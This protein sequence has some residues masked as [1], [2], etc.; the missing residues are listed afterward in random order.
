MPGVAFTL[1][2]RA[3]SKHGLSHIRNLTGI[4]VY[5]ESRLDV[6]RQGDNGRRLIRRSIRLCGGLR[7]RSHW[8]AMYGCAAADDLARTRFLVDVERQM[9]RS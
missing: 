7:T 8:I 1:G 5:D 4:A 2:D 3:G 9:A 6:L